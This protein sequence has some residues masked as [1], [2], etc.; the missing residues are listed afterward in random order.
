MKRIV[1]LM[2]FSLMGVFLLPNKSIACDTMS[3]STEKPVATE[4]E[5]SACCSTEKSDNQKGCC[6]GECDNPFC[7]CVA[8][9]SN[10]PLPFSTLFS[11]IKRILVETKFYYS[12]FAY[13]STFSNI[14]LP[15]KIA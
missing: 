9:F 8:N 12:E 7:N 10:Y 4:T 1:L 6:E 14:W 3:T 11:S 5:E 2:F 15:P 13:S